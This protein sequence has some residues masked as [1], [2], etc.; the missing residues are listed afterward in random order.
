MMRKTA[1][2]IDR[3]QHQEDFKRMIDIIAFDAD[4]TLWHNEVY[5]QSA[6]EELKRILSPWAQPQMIAD[7]LNM[8]EMRNLP[9]YGYGIKAFVLSMIEAAYLV[10]EGQM[11]GETIEKIL[12]IGR[13]MLQAE[14]TLFPH[15]EDT[16]HNLS[17]SFRLMVITKGD[18]LDQIRKI[19]RSGL[20]GYF[21]LVE[22]IHDKT[23]EAYQNILEKYHFNHNGFIMVGN[24]LRSD[25][26]PVLELGGTAVHIPANTS[27][28]HENIP[29]FNTSQN[30]YYRLETIKQLPQLIKDLSPS[31]N[32]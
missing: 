18:P 12:A 9:I 25:V 26:V 10:S 20:E 29:D 24:S 30:G 32:D 27:W 23:R 21:S 31:K 1:S 6:Q 14:I 8:I 3:K 19:E 15:V 4:D 7:R 11:G 13:Q 22:V 5:Y 16:L 28:D 17:R 2:I